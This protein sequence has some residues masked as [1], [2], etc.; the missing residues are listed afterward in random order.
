MIS[1]LIATTLQNSQAYETGFD[2]GY[3]LGLLFP[4]AI[5]GALIFLIIKVVK[6]KSKK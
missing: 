2:I 6:K 5:I 3:I 4:F 1:L